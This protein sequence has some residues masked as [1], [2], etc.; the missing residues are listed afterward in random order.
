[1]SY[2][3]IP[4]ETTALIAPF[5]S[6]AQRTAV[7]VGVNISGNGSVTEAVRVEVQ[8]FPSTNVMLYF[9]ALKQGMV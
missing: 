3:E 2:A 9:P 4:P 1:M 6:P 8:L 7:G 5:D